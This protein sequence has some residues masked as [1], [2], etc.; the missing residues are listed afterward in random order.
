[1]YHVYYRCKCLPLVSWI[2]K[3]LT[4]DEKWMHL[5][6]HITRWMFPI[7]WIYLIFC[8]RNLDC[9]N[10][11]IISWESEFWT[12][13]V[14]LA[15]FPMSKNFE[16]RTVKISNAFALLLLTA[17]LQLWYYR[18]SGIHWTWFASIQYAPLLAQ[19]RAASAALR[20][21]RHDPSHLGDL[22]AH[23]APSQWL[24]LQDAAAESRIQPN[25]CKSTLHMRITVTCEVTGASDTMQTLLV[26]SRRSSQQ[27]I[28]NE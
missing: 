24:I 8:Y 6:S 12:A 9:D 11:I 4:L 22:Q 17:K 27:T 14:V 16:R 28:Q 5:E 1:M 21:H 26:C 23:L 10:R 7:I 19:P 20:Q 3:N 25:T 2:G 15:K 13:H 18:F